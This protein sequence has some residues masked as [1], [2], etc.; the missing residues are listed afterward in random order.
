MNE[1]EKSI[2]KSTEKIII[3]IRNQTQQIKEASKKELEFLFNIW[4]I[5][6]QLLDLKEKQMHM[7]KEKNGSDNANTSPSK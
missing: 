5:E 4:R 6:K 2:E 1:I 7:E 3:E